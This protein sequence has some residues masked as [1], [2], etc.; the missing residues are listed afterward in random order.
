MARPS[1]L[2]IILR[3]RKIWKTTFRLFV[4][5]ERP[6]LHNQEIEISSKECLALVSYKYKPN[7]FSKAAQP[8]LNWISW[9]YTKKKDTKGNWENSLV[10]SPPTRFSFRSI[11]VFCSRLEESKGRLCKYPKNYLRRSL[12]IELVLLRN[13]IKINWFLFRDLRITEAYWI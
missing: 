11:S 1:F 13:R 4:I 10:F 12:H 9:F 8:F 7:I 5:Y 6:L 2:G 3:R